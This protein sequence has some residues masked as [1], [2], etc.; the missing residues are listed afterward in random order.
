MGLPVTGA[1]TSGADL[2]RGYLAAL[3]SAV[4]LSTTAIFIRHLTVAFQLPPL[5][6]AFWREVFVALTLLLILGLVRPS[7]LRM[8]RR[9]LAFLVA[10]GLTLMIFNALWTTAVAL[11]GAAIATVLVY[12]STAFTALLG[13][14]FLKEKLTRAHLLAIAL[15]LGGCVL[16]AGALNPE[17]WRASLAGVVVGILSGLG[18]A[19]YSLLGR[20]ASRRGLNPWT[21]LLYTFGFASLFFLLINLLPGEVVPG[22][23]ARPGDLLWL[24]GALDGWGI[25]ILLAAGPTVLGFGLYNISLG[26]LATGVANL[27]LTTEPVFTAALAYVL[28]GERL[29][30]LQILGGLM[31]LGGVVLIRLYAPSADTQTG[32]G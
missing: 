19:L 9:H 14:L 23:A 10:F 21:T 31:I 25:L 30:L 4:V 29:S 20:S 2:T 3:G 1:T 27:V 16:V 18:Y 17:A 24:G 6:L 22:S 13:W 26:Y 5:I 7:L 32:G 15:A 28:L 12:C 11:S 8:E